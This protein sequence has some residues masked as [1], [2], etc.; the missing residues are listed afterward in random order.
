MWSYYSRIL[1]SSRRGGKTSKDRKDKNLQYLQL[2]LIVSRFPGGFHR[3]L[4]NRPHRWWCCSQLKNGDLSFYFH[5]FWLFWESCASPKHWPFKNSQV[6]EAEWDRI[7]EEVSG[8]RS[9][10]DLQ[11]PTLGD[12]GSWSVLKML[13]DTTGL[14][15]NCGIEMRKLR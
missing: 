5:C 7:V 10:P 2:I 14:W 11:L 12:V 3:H 13:E 9:I 4:N 15:T 1:A 6:H 8:F